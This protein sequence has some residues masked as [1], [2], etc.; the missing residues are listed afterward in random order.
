MA[1]S[2]T[3]AGGGALAGVIVASLGYP[4]LAAFSALLGLGVVAAGAAVARH[5]R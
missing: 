5:A 4:A 2:R 3:A 1:M